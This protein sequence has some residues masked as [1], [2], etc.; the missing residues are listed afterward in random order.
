MGETEIAVRIASVYH[1]IA[2]RNPK[3][4]RDRAEE[5]VQHYAAR[6]LE[7]STNTLTRIWLAAWVRYLEE[8]DAQG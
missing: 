5:R 4:T 2:S 6:R 1:V 7:G 8:L 3:P